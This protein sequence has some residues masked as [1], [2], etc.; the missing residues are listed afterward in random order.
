MT[1]LIAPQF[2]YRGGR[3]ETG[4]AIEMQGDRIAAIR[5]LGQDRPDL[6]PFLAMP[7]CVDLQ[8]NGGGGVMLNSTP[9]PQGV[10]AIVAAHRARGT[11]W[12]MPTVI[13][14]APEI[15]TAAAH[16]VLECKDEPGVLG[17][18]LEG[19]HI[20]AARRGT[21]RAE[22]IRPFD[23]QSM[24]LL[25]HLRAHGLLVLLTLAPECVGAQT[26]RQILDLGVV[27]SIGHT[28]ATATQTQAALD[29]GATCFT[30]LYNAMP[31]MTSRDPGVVGTAIAS[32]AWC[33]LIADG[34]HVSWPM[35]QI[36][37]R[38]RPVP[39][40]MFLV[41]DAMATV[42]GPDQFELYGETIRLRGGR[43]INAEGS[44]AG[45][46]IDMLQSLH[47]AHRHIGLPLETA[48]AMSTDTPCAAMNL[49]PPDLRAGRSRDEM[50][51]LDTNLLPVWVTQ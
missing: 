5:P 24:V 25:T 41:S 8:V 40:R 10:M 47:N 50:L 49:P 14:D 6:T 51:V 11:G 36:A 22:F 30:H 12:I 15:M 1:R 48:I 33:G 43:L 9:T 17:L 16:A 32:Q 39:G 45:A 3:L 19:P 20:A 2:L 26:L 29:N 38:A 13:T 18:H 44:L 31:P 37:C 7:A 21:H 27:V 34:I 4:L 23:D 28:T 46:H 35:A 42:G